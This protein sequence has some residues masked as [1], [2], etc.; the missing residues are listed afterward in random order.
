[1]RQYALAQG[2]PDEDIVLDYAGR[3][4]GRS[5]RDTRYRADYFP[6]WTRPSSSPGRFRQVRIARYGDLLVDRALYQCDK[7]GIDAAGVAA[8]RRDYRSA[9]FWWLRA[10]PLRAAVSRAWLDLNLLHP[11]P[12][13]GE[14]LPII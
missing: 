7:L 9:R 10:L 5:D 1:M 4:T 11:T 2:V 13:L 12:V 14:K 8:E 6:A 3:W